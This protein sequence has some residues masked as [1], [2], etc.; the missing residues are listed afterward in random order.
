MEKL[1][2][3]TPFEKISYGAG[4]VGCTVVWNV[5]G[6]FMTIYYTDD[7][8]IS[9]AAVAAIMLSVKMFDGFSDLV[10]GYLLDRTNS[11]LG[12]A[13]PWILWTSPFLCSFV[14]LCF[15]VPDFANYSLKVAYAFLTYFFLTV[16][17]YTSCNLAFC[18]LQ[19]FCS[20]SVEERASMNSYR[21]VMTAVGALILG[22]VTPV[23]AKSLGWLG[24]TS[25]YGAIAFGLL[26]LCFFV[27]KERVKPQPRAAEDKVTV[28]ESLSVLARNKYF[29][30][31]VAFFVIDFA[32][33]GLTGA[34]GMYLARYILQDDTFFGHLNFASTF[35]QLLACFFFPFI[36]KLCKGKWNAIIFGYI[37]YIIGYGMCQLLVGTDMTIGSFDYYLMLVGSA[38]K[39]FGWGMHLV[40]MFAMIAD[41]VEYGEWV[42]GRR[43]DGATY[44][45]SSFGFK[46]GLGVGGSIVGW[47]LSLVNYDATLAV[48]PQETLEAILNIN[49]FIPL[50]LSIAGLVISLLGNLDKIHPQ[51]MKD[52]TVRRAEEAA[53]FGAAQ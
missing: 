35:P 40:A 6:M 28:K 18:S 10:M 26:M 34:S 52:L 12:K 20:N 51:V 4:D 46:I 7:L 16:V 53:K 24:I 14:V 19:S 30:F 39:G 8:G 36:M 48:Q 49:F 47:A 9:A 1:R 33:A 11:K 43:L 5:V 3:L 27:C 22:Y 45:V 13:R 37:L 23:A 44:S 29:F 2:P 21:F 50:V 42:T 25:L 15:T 17:F 38:I 31:L 32:N 41:V